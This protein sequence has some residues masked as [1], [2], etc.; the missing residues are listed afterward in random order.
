MSDATAPDPAAPA[1]R[2]RLP[3]I[4]GAGL[5][6]VL[7]A[8]GFLAAYSGL[9]PFG[10]HAGD[11]HQ[12]APD[13]PAVS[14]VPIDPILV[15]IEDVSGFRH[16]RFRA[17][18]EVTPGAQEPVAALMPRILDVLNGFLRAV[19]V[20][21]LERATSL[22]RLR[23]QMLRRIQLVTGEGQVRDLLVT[24]FVLN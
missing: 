11:A 4:A 12:A 19:D 6:L 7:G 24:E 14:F 23:A 16:L 8:A 9:L 15:S 20:S 3:L 10:G 22:V 2:R 5:A 13:L 1:P 21:E 17:E 18:L